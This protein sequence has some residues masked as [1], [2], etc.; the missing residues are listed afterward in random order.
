MGE[1]RLERLSRLLQ[2][3]IGALI[4][5]GRIK[6]PRVDTF[7]SITRVRVSRDISYAEVHVSS[8][9]TPEGLAKGVAGLQSAAGFIQSQFAKDVRLR[10]TPR[11]R[12]FED[13]GVREGF[14]LIKRIETLSS[15]GEAPVAA[16]N[17]GGAPEDL[18]CHEAHG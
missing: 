17:D 12:F 18:S 10:Q 15:G 13:S 16:H 6:D 5:E 11:L 7:L 3:K 8:F 1:Y 14:D 9:K 2:E 4:V